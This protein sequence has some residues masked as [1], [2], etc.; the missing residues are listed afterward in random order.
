MLIEFRTDKFKIITLNKVD[1]GP[2]W[3]EYCKNYVG[4]TSD[5]VDWFFLENYFYRIIL[6]KFNYYNTLKD[7]FKEQ[8]EESLKLAMKKFQP[9]I[10]SINVQTT[11]RIELLKGYLMKM[12]WGNRNDLSLS[13]GKVE[14]IEELLSSDYL[15]IDESNDICSLLLNE[16]T[17]SV[18]IVLDNCGV[19]LLSDIDFSSYLINNLK[20]SVTL[21]CSKV[22][23]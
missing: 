20:L 6:N 15:L 18:G 1:N 17:K 22:L 7:P 2:D 4:K 9:L 14:E 16:K 3:T 10:S 13:G 12:L 21:Y 23:I 19:E 8:K 11:S 5:K